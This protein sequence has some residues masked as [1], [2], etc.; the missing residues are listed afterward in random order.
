MGGRLP[1]ESVA[2]LRRITHAGEGSSRPPLEPAAPS[3]V[4]TVDQDRPGGRVPADRFEAPE[5]WQRMASAAYWPV[6]SVD[7]GEHL[8]AAD[9]RSP[10]PAEALELGHHGARGPH[11]EDA[12]ARRVRDAVAQHSAL[13]EALS[14]PEGPT[15]EGHDQGLLRGKM[16]EAIG[17]VSR[18]N[19][20]RSPNA[21]FW[22]SRSSL[23]PARRLPAGSG[24]AGRE[25][26]LPRQEVLMGEDYS[27]QLRPAKRQRTLSPLV[28]H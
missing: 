13:R 25:R 19:C 3:H 27:G 16:N 10:L 21:G 26:P 8:D 22:R 7:Q 17:V 1:S 4:Q 5:P 12:V 15:A 23:E 28:K 9:L 14:W 2:G 11:P 20:A 24:R 6:Q 18:A